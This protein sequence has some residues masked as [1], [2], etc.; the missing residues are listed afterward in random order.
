MPDDVVTKL[1]GVFDVDPRCFT[2]DLSRAEMEEL[3]GETWFRTPVRLSPEAR[4]A[5][6]DF[7]GYMT[8]QEERNKREGTQTRKEE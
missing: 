8:A 1:A 4:R 6:E 3:L 7:I 2:G 5:V